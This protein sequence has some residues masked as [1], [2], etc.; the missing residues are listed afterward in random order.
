MRRSQV[1]ASA[2]EPE[3]RIRRSQVRAEPPAPEPKIPDWLWLFWG[4]NEPRRPDPVDAGA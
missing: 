4:L 3:P 2:V 1:V